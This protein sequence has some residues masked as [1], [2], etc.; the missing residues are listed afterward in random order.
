VQALI[1]GNEGRVYYQAKTLK[2]KTSGKQYNGL[3]GNL[4]VG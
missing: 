4:P 1:A 2:T 3:P